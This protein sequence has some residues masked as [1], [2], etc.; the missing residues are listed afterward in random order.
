MATLF[1]RRGGSW[2]V[3]YFHPL[4]G[5]RIDQP[6]RTTDKRVAERIRTK[7]EHETTLVKA[8]L[9]DPETSGS[10]ATDTKKGKQVAEHFK[11]YLAHCSKQRQAPKH[12]EEKRRHFANLRESESLSLLSDLKPE[13]LEGNLSQMEDSGLSASY[14]NTRRKIMIAFM[15][16]AVRWGRAKENTLKRVAKRDERKDR[17]RR[18]RPYTEE[19]LEKFFSVAEKQGR[20]AWYL[21]AYLGGLRKG[22]L[23]RLPWK[24][25][26]FEG[27]FIRIG[28]GK[29]KREDLIPLHP[30]L[31]EELLRIR[32]PDYSPTA[33]VF[34]KAVTD[35]TRLRDL[36]RAGLA[37]E[38]EYV[39][40][41]GSVR[42][43]IRTEDAEGRVLDL[44]AFR[45]TLHT[46]LARRGV[47][48]QVAQQIMRHQDYRTTLRHYTEL[49]LEDAKR[50][51]QK[52]SSQPTQPQPEKPAFENDHRNNHTN[53]HTRG[54]SQGQTEPNSAIQCE[55]PPSPEAPKQARPASEV[56]AKEG[57]KEWACP[58]SNRELPP[59][60]GGTLAN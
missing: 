26:E 40:A 10:F 18:R 51:L 23:Q 19:E 34:P 58:D 12:L 53:N 16:W 1:Q 37:R 15:A 55:S 36:L 39:A 20:K 56:L 59:C 32:P 41:N 9:L 27:G 13:V 29:A 11:D 57:V 6:T 42:K 48:L 17:R 52:V 22:D 44:H 4:S 50:A 38:E 30:E 46:T 49:Q 21:C 8:G 3:R 54:A 5:K 28:E 60:K 25:V 35:R 33:K 2:V 7:L 14:V 47:P 45:T 43:R 31:A 24:D